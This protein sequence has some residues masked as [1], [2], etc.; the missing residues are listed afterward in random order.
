MSSP[1]P[2]A[3][4]LEHSRIAK[5][6]IKEAQ[7]II[8]TCIADLEATFAVNLPH[9]FDAAL[10]GNSLEADDGPTRSHES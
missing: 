9:T 4:L 10:T 7:S 8:A 1:D 3:S 5:Q 2:L 6:A